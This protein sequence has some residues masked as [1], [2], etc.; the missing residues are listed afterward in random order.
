MV[1]AEK[2]AAAIQ[3][4]KTA[5][6]SDT[7]KKSLESMS[8]PDDYTGPV[9]PGTEK[10]R[11]NEDWVVSVLEWMKEGKVLAKK[12]GYEII[13][14]VLEVLKTHGTVE[15]ISLEEGQEITTCGDVHGEFHLFFLEI[16]LLLLDSK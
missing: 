3:S 7:A 9:Y 12:T 5:P 16:I 10:I 6:P 13:L 4:E 1:N 11:G 14:D 8:V 15:Y 2:F